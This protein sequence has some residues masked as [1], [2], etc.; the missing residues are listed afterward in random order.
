MSIKPS[1]KMRPGFPKTINKPNPNDSNENK[2]LSLKM[3]PG[4][5]AAMMIDSET[6]NALALRRTCLHRRQH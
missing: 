2:T 5:Y 6:K 4:F 1:P 3:R